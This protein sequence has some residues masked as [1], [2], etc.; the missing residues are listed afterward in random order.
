MIENVQNNYGI[1]EDV[2]RD[3]EINP[4]EEKRIKDSY[5]LYELSKL[6]ESSMQAIENIEEF[7]EYKQYMHI[8]REVEKK[9]NQVLV[10]SGGSP[11]SSL[12]LLCGSVG[13]GKSHLLGR[14]RYYEPE[15]MEKFKIHNDATESF[16]PNQSSLDTLDRVLSGFR[17]E[18]IANS[19]E[20]MVLAI[21]LGVLHNFLESAYASKYSKLAGFIS[22]TG[23]FKAADEFEEKD[24][25]YFSLVNFG[26]YELFELT[27]QG[28]Q[29]NYISELLQRVTRNTSENPF[30]QAY[31]LDTKRGKTDI[32]I[33]NYELLLQENIQQAIVKLIAKTVF[34]YKEIISARALF[35]FIYDILVPYQLDEIEEDPSLYLS[36][37]LPNLIFGLEDRSKLLLNI[38]YYDPINLRNQKIDELLVEYY[39][40]N[41]LVAFF[42]KYIMIDNQDIILIKLEESI[43][44]EILDKDDF[45]KTFI[46][47]YYFLN[48][49][50]VVLDTQDF[51]DDY[52][53]TL[54]GYHSFDQDILGEFSLL[55]QEAVKLWNGSPKENYVY[56][57]SK[58]ET[59]KISH[60]LD[61]EVD[62]DFF[63]S[64]V[65][66]KN[67]VLGSYQHSAKM[68][69][70]GTKHKDKP[71]QIDIDLPLYVMLKN[72]VLGYRPN[73]KDRQ[74]A[75]QM[76]EFMENLIKETSTPKKVLMNMNKGEYLFS[77]SSEK[78]FTKEKYVFKRESL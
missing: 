19:E 70:I 2:F 18:N 27:H 57:N 40:T 60:E 42:K 29:S 56:A 38:Q 71:V 35:N 69:F 25:L 44:K 32:F 52:I 20:K 73:K 11:F 64:F 63:E 55:I 48:K 10:E 17:D 28:I 65:E 3:T 6:K 41:N 68:S 45:I 49:D 67:A 30:Y 1:D 51:F 47:F 16:E 53:N 74:D 43:Q 24:S 14:F 76:E 4:V 50:S 26:D 23:L 5:L 22:G 34:Y 58:N 21:N 77:L 62:S 37:L 13:D 75:L 61:Y 15:L 33:K 9:L 31:L 12:V 66:K 46:R 36:N 7:S 78:S 59:V 39:N 54:Y 8:E 72:V